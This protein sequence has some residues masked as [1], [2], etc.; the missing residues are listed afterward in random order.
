MKRKT[1]GSRRPQESRE[2][3]PSRHTCH[4]ASLSAGHRGCSG[5]WP[6]QGWKPT[7]DGEGPGRPSSSAGHPWPG[8]L[9]G[10]GAF[11]SQ[12]IHISEGGSAEPG[13]GAEVK[14]LEHSLHVCLAP[15]VTDQGCHPPGLGRAWEVSQGSPR[16]QTWMAL[17]PTH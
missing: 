14:P 1:G 6:S 5:V 17:L 2:P 13:Q 3:Q 16:R 15:A 7:R 8:F 11:C 10:W 4:R 12:T 9:Q